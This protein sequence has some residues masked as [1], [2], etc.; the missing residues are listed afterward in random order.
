MPSPPLFTQSQSSHSL[1][2]SFEEG[3][4]GGAGGGSRPSPPLGTR[5]QAGGGDMSIND[6]FAMQLMMSMLAGEG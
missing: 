6:I 1:G 2:K 5:P 4:A 3:G